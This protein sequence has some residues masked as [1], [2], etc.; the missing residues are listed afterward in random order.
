MTEGVVAI[1]IADTNVQQLVG[2]NK[3]RDKF[4]VYPV[5]VPQGESH[6]YVAVKMTSRPPMECKGQRPSAFMPTVNVFCYA[7]N[8]EDALD[9]EAAVIDA[10]DNKEGGV[11]GGQSLRYLRY[12]NSAEDFIQTNDGLGLY[13]RTPQFEAQEDASAPT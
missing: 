3:A 7:Q 9:I 13:V 5:V 2:E 12:T 4:K 8:Y 11:Y 10:L 6:P 1:L